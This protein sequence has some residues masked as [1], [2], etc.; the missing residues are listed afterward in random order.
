MLLARAQSARFSSDVVPG[1]RHTVAPSSC[2][3]WVMP[4]SRR[5]MKPWPS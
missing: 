1:W 4:S 2:R 5:S 3:A